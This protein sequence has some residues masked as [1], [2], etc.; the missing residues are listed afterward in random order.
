M[1]DSFNFEAE[2]T[3]PTW[4][5]WL[6][7]AADLFFGFAAAATFLGLVSLVAG[8][9]PRVQFD[10]TYLVPCRDVTTPEFV[11]TNP[12]QRLIEARV[13]VS[14]LIVAGS[15]SDITQH[16]YRFDGMLGTLQVHD[17]LPKT[18]LETRYAS[19]IATKNNDEEGAKLT[20]NLLGQY[21]KFSTG[22]VSAEWRKNHAANSEYTLLP[23]MEAVA[24]SG[25]LNR[26]RSAYF[27]LRG[28]ERTWLEG[29]KEFAVILAAPQSWQAD[30]LRVRCEAE[31]IRRI[32]GK[33]VK[34][35]CGQREFLVGLF[36]EGDEFAR[37]AAYQLV[38]AESQLRAKAVALRQRQQRASKE[39]PFG[40]LAQ[41]FGA[42]EQRASDNWL[43]RITWST[44]DNAEVL[45]HLPKE[46]RPAA[47]R[48]RSARQEIARL[49]GSGKKL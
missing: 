38:A 17:Y 4:R 43:P 47:E 45:A 13:Q 8:E 48:F 49:A 34:F 6:E 29:A 46:I 36:N 20:L 12:G 7:P 24:A 25:T 3:A 31:G 10:T 42:K 30:Y 35:P 40:L 14:S 15:E 9:E 39:N 26:G 28:N 2:K 21:E 11:A 5:L 32:D 19:P 44:D 41:A 37:A 18:T 33:D 22:G 1:C 23:P 27:K 16:V